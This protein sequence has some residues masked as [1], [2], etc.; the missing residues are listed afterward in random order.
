[1]RATLVDANI[2]LDLVTNDPVWGEWSAGQLAAAIS[3]GPL[4]VNDVIY[5]EISIRFSEI[6]KLDEMLADFRVV[7]EAIPRRALF[8]AGKAF[9]RYRSAGGLRGS[10]LPDFFIGA[11]AAA[12]DLR[13]LTRDA[14]RYRTYYPE[15]DLVTP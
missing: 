4:L 2:F 10:V 7:H 12:A 13:L 3:S 5:A 6:G 9:K 11:H 1:M 14:R 8:E 15:V